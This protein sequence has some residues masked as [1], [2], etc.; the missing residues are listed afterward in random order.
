[1]PA[2]LPA[3]EFPDEDL[4]QRIAAVNEGT[5]HFLVDPPDKPVHHH[6]NEIQI[7]EASLHDG[8]VVL[9]QC[10]RHLDAV[11][12]AQIVFNARR[13]GAI[14]VL[15]HTNIEDVRVEG[16]TVQLEGIGKEAVLCLRIKTQAL[17][18]FG[19]PPRYRLRN[20][21][22]MRRFLDGYY[23]MRV[24]MTIRYPVSMLKAVE[25]TPE[26]QP[27]L[28][29]RQTPGVIDLDTWFEGR[30]VTEFTFCRTARELCLR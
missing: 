4:Q 25:H 17:E 29:I 10:H 15:E 12:A 13:T 5:L 6:H 14:E 18:Q 20:G 19:D 16:P 24:S 21:P 7:T 1:M 27:G 11:P 30:L 26:Q 23:P 3:S 9:E 28:Q 8:W 22:F 2:H